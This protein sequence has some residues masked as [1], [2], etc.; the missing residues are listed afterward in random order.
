MMLRQSV[1]WIQSALRK[2]GLAVKE[3][4]GAEF[5]FGRQTWLRIKR[6]VAS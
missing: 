3:L 1:R 5:N 6:G 2:Q 4:A